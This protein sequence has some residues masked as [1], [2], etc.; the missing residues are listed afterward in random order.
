MR[1]ELASPCGI[2]SQHTVTIELPEVEDVPVDKLKNSAVTLKAELARL[3][4]LANEITEP[5]MMSGL[6]FLAFQALN[7]TGTVI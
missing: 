3:S 7:G 5:A 2:I 1:I 6:V 4:L